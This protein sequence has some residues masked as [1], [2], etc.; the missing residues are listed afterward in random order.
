MSPQ[1]LTIEARTPRAC[2]WTPSANTAARMAIRQARSSAPATSHAPR[3]RGEALGDAALGD[4][5]LVEAVV[6]DAGEPGHAMREHERHRRAKVLVHVDHP[7]QRLVVLGDEA[8]LALGGVEP[9]DAAGAAARPDHHDRDVAVLLHQLDGGLERVL[10]A[11][12]RR[13]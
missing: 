12:P 1:Y 8:P 7:G 13:V 2:I 10:A 4:V 3:R 9:H 11:N 5:A 6:V